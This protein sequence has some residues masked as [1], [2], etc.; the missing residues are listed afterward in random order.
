[1][2]CYFFNAGFSFLKKLF[3][4]ENFRTSPCGPVTKTPWAQW[5]AGRF[6]PWSGN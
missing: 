5:G 4:K 6:N 2:M 1:M 3:I